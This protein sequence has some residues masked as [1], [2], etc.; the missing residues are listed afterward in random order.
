MKRKGTLL[1]WNENLL[2]KRAEGIR[3]GLRHHSG[4]EPGETNWRFKI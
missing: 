1:E 4:Q 2:L 3:E